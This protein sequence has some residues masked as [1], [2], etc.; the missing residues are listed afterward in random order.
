MPPRE[1]LTAVGKTGIIPVTVKKVGPIYEEG[2]Q[3]QAPGLLRRQDK[4][5]RPGLGDPPAEISERENKLGRGEGGKYL[6]GR[7]NGLRAKGKCLKGRRQGTRP[8]EI[9]V[10]TSAKSLLGRRT[11]TGRWAARGWNISRTG[12]WSFPDE[13][14]KP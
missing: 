8:R 13:Q 4:G 10:R 11:Q 3:G 1:E 7:R 9:V 5:N 12:F 2:F 6:K 14:E